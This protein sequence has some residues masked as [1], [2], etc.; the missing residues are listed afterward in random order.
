MRIKYLLY[1]GNPYLVNA[2]LGITRLI[3]V[4]FLVLSCFCHFLLPHQKKVTKVKVAGKTNR[5]LFFT[6]ATPCFPLQK[7]GTVRTFSGFAP[8]TAS[9]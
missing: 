3:R 4:D 2:S 6:L 5:T 9:L 1:S 7:K 8:R